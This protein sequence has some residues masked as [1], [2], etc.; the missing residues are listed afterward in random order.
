MAKK[1]NKRTLCAWSKSDIEEQLSL[2]ARVTHSP[3]YACQKCARVASSPKQLCKPI[4]LPTLE[5]K[6]LA[7]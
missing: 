3:S 1:L 4:S 2:L 7:G 5:P 6:F